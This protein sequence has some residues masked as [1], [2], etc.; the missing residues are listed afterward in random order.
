MNWN[1]AAAVAVYRIFQPRGGDSGLEALRERL[2]A[3]VD[4]YGPHAGSTTHPGSISDQFSD[5]GAHALR[6]GRSL[7]FFIGA[8]NQ[9]RI[10]AVVIKKQLDYGHANISR[11]GRIGLMVRLHD[12]VARLENL[13]QPGRTP[14]NESI[15]DNVMDVIGY[16]IL[17]IMWE[18]GTFL[19]RVQPLTVVESALSGSHRT[20]MS[21]IFAKTGYK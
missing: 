4:A 10:T 20:G 14:N 11:F 5:L 17:G 12:K 9:D 6:L 13:L 2:D 7:G 18:E 8:G 21:D 19:L 16:C 1:Q 3:M 15:E